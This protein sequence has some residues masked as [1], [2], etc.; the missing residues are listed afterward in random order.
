MASRD[1]Y[2]VLGLEKGAS[3]A[4]IKKAFRK[5]AIK[6]HP[7]KN[8]GNAEAEKKFKEINEAYQVLSDPDKKAK[9]D[10]FGTADFDGSGFG[11]GAGGFGGF[12]FSDMG[13]FGDIFDTFFG[14]GGGSSSARRNGPRRGADIE[15]TIRL[16]FEEAIKGVEKEISIT[17]N[18]NCETCNG[19][20]AKPGTTPQTCPVCHGSGQVRVQRQTP[21][22]S[23]VSTTTCDKCHGTGKIIEEPCPTCKGKGQVRKTRKIKVNIPAGVDT[24][25]VIPLRGQGEHGTN[26]GPAGDL[27]IKIVVA[28]SKQFTRRGVDIYVDTH[29]SMAK[30]ALGTEITVETVDGNVKYTVPAGTQSGTLFRLKGKGVPRVNGSG[31]GDQYVKVIVDIPKK[32]NDKQKEALMMFMEASG[33]KVEG[34]KEGHHKKGFK[35][36]FK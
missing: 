32:L 29:I 11:A 7:D 13:G 21:L 27:Y 31:R 12:D 34:A 9:Y 17:R 36:L 22:G 4:E 35:D 10:Q 15:Y 33:E 16:T 18:E 23:F 25:N 8:Q 2:E 19:S 5:L 28:P 20:G 14:G 3:D 30:A 24:G 26:G 6:Y 1:Y